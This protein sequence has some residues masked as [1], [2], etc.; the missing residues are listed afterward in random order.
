MGKGD[1]W[2][3]MADAKTICMEALER[4]CK[5]G[6]IGRLDF[7]RD[8]YQGQ[9]FVYGGF[10]VHAYLAGLEGVPALFRLFDW[11][12]ARIEWTP[13]DISEHTSLNL[14]MQAACDLYA[15]N[16]ADRATWDSKDKERLDKA[17]DTQALMLGETVAVE[18]ALKNYTISLEC[19]DRG[20]LPNG[21]TFSARDKPSYVIGS[22]DECDVILRH[23]SVD[24]MHCGVILENGSVYIWDLGAQSGIKLNGTPVEQGM[25]RVGDVMT[26]GAVDLQVRFQLRRPNINRPLTVPLP[27]LTA[28]SGPPPKEIPKGAITYE[29]V[30]KALRNSDKGKPFLTKLGSL[31]GSKD[32]K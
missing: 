25:L 14:S 4:H 30:S 10:I 26:L 23:P 15:E 2:Y 20:L 6:D 32:Q 3:P 18:S 21:F 9:I 24:A 28:R 22:S 19:S 12:D 31:F 7:H 1:S 5:S 16:L 13:D 11:G 17:F 27:N 29:K 8:A